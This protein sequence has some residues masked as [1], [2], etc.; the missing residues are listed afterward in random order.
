MFC[1]FVSLPESRTW[2]SRKRN[3]VPGVGSGLGCGGCERLLKFLVCRVAGV[4]AEGC[5]LIAG[6]VSHRNCRRLHPC[7][8]KEQ[9][10]SRQE[11]L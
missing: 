10:H 9:P 6:S 8:W 4:R 3:F 5:L 2:H 1:A 7:R 11:N